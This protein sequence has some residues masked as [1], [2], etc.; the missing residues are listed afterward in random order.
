MSAQ[1][2]NIE[3]EVPDEPGVWLAVSAANY[4]DAD[5]AFWKVKQELAGR[6]LSPAGQ[7]HMDQLLQRRKDCYADL[8]IWMMTVE[9]ERQG[10]TGRPDVTSV[11]SR[12]SETGG[13]L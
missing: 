6:E 9:A 1:G 12:S 11:T 7:A 3:I 10:A 5:T 4:A 8:V 2:E 13:Y